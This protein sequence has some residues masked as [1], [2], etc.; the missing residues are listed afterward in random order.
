[1][2]SLEDFCKRCRPLLDDWASEL[3]IEIEW[4]HGWQKDGTMRATAFGYYPGTTN[5][6]ATMTVVVPVDDTG[7]PFMS[8]VAV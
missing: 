7:S 2:R 3:G 8:S 1:M 4:V 6:P 5:N